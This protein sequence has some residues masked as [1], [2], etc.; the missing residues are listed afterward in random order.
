L[1]QSAAPVFAA[2]DALPLAGIRVVEMSQMV[3]GPTCGMILGDLG[4]EVIKVEPLPKGDRTRD[5]KGIGVGFFTAFNRNKK[6]LALDMKSPAARQALLKLV[7]GADVMLENFRPGGIERL[8]FGYAAMAEVNPRLVYCTLKGF[9]P[10]P[11]ENRA[12]LD[13]VAQM[14]SGLAYMTGLPGKPMRAGAS[15][16]DIMGAMFAVIAIQAA[17]AERLRTGRGQR[18]SSA[19][20]ETCS[21]LVSPFALNEAIE[22][23]V[24]PP[25]SVRRTSW[26]IYDLFETA[27]GDQIFL[28][29]VGDEQWRDF[30]AAFGRPDWAARPDLATMNQR[31]MSR[32]W[33]I[34]EVAAI[35]K[36]LPMAE[37]V[38][39][40]EARAIG[41][42]PVNRPG[43]LL[44]DPHLAASGGLVEVDLQDGRRSRTLSLPL[45]IG[46]KRM[47][48]RL[49]PPKLGEHNAEVLGG[50]GYSAAEI[51]ALS[52]PP[53]RPETGGL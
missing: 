30:C 28:A 40:C 43:Q 20:F 41:F 51:A 22:R 21:F 38:A 12:A 34:P 49:Q 14:M 35:M 23:Q 19:L 29:V 6:S 31:T 53:V 25:M 4:A 17:L 45:A 5:L 50:L 48:L 16:T 42:A 37:I 39:R 2:P 46:G 7:S 47:P 9:L 15:V 18:V 32:D 3:M 10:G 44:D 36:T 13:E 27:D 24:C 33:L 26:P 1:T 52:R 11:Y 8:G